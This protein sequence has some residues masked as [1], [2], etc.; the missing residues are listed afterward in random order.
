MYWVKDKN[1]CTIIPQ[2]CYCKCAYN[3]LALH[4]E[5]DN[6]GRLNTK[7]YEKC[8]D[9]PFSVVNFFISSN[10]PPS[11]IALFE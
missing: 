9:F 1:H 3:V 7:L 5:I 6:G 2:H 10:I 4:L 11:N 8:D